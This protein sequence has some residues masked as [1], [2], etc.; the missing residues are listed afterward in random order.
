[1]L[2]KPVLIALFAFANLALASPLGSLDLNGCEGMNKDDECEEILLPGLSI[3]GVCE[4]A[5]VSRI[6]TSVH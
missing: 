3:K 5:A 1:M 4:N 6:F 2:N